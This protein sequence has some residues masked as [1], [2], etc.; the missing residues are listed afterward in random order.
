MDWNDPKA[1]ECYRKEA[2]NITSHYARALTLQAGFDKVGHDEQLVVL[3]NACGTAIVSLHLYDVLPNDAKDNLELLC[4][5]ISAP[6]LATVEQRIKE[7]GWKG[8]K[9]QIVDTHDTK[10]PSNHFTHVLTNFGFVGLKKP[11]TALDEQNRIL[12]PGG[13]LALTVWESTGWF[14]YTAEAVRSLPSPPHFPTW[15]EFCNAFVSEE[16]T[17]PRKWHLTS[18]MVE[19]IRSHGFEDVQTTRVKSHTRH[20]SAK[21]YCEVYVPMLKMI[22]ATFWNEEQR[23]KYGGL[24]EAALVKRLEEVFGEGEIVLDWE[25]TIIVGKKK[26]N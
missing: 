22:T 4:G 13:T 19:Q 23:E 2:E 6:M 11:H 21:K 20:E 10:L 9:T 7:Y 3:D 25:A 14:E 26:M 8:A 17:G 16:D 15:P 18:F 12:R 1:V 5:D 24:V